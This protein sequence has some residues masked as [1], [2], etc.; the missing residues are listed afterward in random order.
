MWG[1]VS[2][3]V[4]LASAVF[5]TGAQANTI[6]H[7]NGSSGSDTGTCQSS[8]CQTISYAITQGESVPDLVTI[9]VGP[10]TYNE[11]L[12]L[13]AADSGL[14]I[15]GSGSGGDPASATIVNEVGSSPAILTTNTTSATSL[16]LNDVRVVVPSGFNDPAIAGNT[17]DVS[18]DN[19]AIDV[20][21]SALGID[22][23]SGD[24]AATGSSITESN[25]TA[26][27]AIVTTTAITLTSTPIDDGGNSIALSGAPIDLTGSPVTMSNASSGSPA[28]A[29][30]HQSLTLTS[31]PIDV[32]GG[33]LAIAATGAPLNITDSAITLEDT[34]SAA[35]AI[36]DTSG[37]SE[38]IVTVSGAPITVKGVG[39]AIVSTS[40]AGRLSNMQVLQQNPAATAPALEL[41]GRGSSLSAVT[42]STA[43]TAPAL[44][45]EGS[46]SIADSSIDSTA[47]TAAPAL[48]LSGGADGQDISVQRSTIKQ[49]NASTPLITI[50]TANVL[51]DSSELL[52]GMGINFTA[53]GGSP[54]TLTIASSTID[55]GTL[56]VRDPAPV[57]SVAASA[58]NTAGSD[59]IVDVEG[60]ILVEP[61]SAIVGGSS[62]HA[63]VNC[64]DTEVP[65]TTQTATASL[66]AINCGAANG[67]T[68]SASLG[69]IFQSPGT[70]YAPNPSWNGVDSV[71]AGAIAVPSPFTD[72]STDLAG[73]PRVLNGVGTC[74]LGLRDKGAIELS[75]HGGV[76]PKPGI[77]GPK[78]TFTGVAT[79]FSAS[80]KN[81]SSASYGWTSSDH[82]SGTGAKFTH[83]FARAGAFTVSVTATGAAGCVGSASETVTVQGVDKITHVS[84]SPKALKNTATVSYTGTTAATTTFT[85]QTKSKKGY[86]AVEH[87]THHDGAGKV[88]V[89]LHKGKLAPGSYRLELQSKNGAGK[90]KPAF[91]AFT[92]K[93]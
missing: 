24:F 86:K 11:D 77:S 52:G 8:A 89:T 93:G 75:G 56:G 49:Q 92:V 17:T 78:S 14:T 85:V 43:S 19:V 15:T 16:A 9:D 58:D 18:L 1:R 84:I 67:N 70:N 36:G 22:L 46:M 31:S 87:F 63:V 39:P 3:L 27:P 62:G 35:P 30:S 51:L 29:I 83:K 54:H 41:D 40:A 79:T 80:A 59:A 48:F 32:A 55:A 68:F 47:A 34:T 37:G 50:N 71:P 20:I 6:L 57:Q 72:S 28:I 42:V 76:I 10:G 65:P 64:F 33:G 2:L 44:F 23:A 25:P 81:V 88:K 82:G 73:N 74:E 66:G 61:P 69:S 60:S 90:G 4:L 38:D 13:N 12:K 5:A 53:T 21:G 7:V 26:G 91:I 45:A